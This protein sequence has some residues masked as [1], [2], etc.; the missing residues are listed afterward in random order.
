MMTQYPLNDGGR[1][2]PRVYILPKV[3]RPIWT[4]GG[5]DARN[6][7]HSSPRPDERR[8]WL[9]RPDAPRAHAPRDGGMKELPVKYFKRGQPT[10]KG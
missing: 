8:G 6:D 4:C 2:T 7:A 3:P 5:F 1:P 9:P 10:V